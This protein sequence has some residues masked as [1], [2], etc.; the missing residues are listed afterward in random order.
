MTGIRRLPLV[1][2]TA[3]A[4]AFTFAPGCEGED[5]DEGMGSPGDDRGIGK[6]DLSGS[7]VDACGDQ[8]ASGCWCDD[9]CSEFGDCCADIADACPDQVSECEAGGGTCHGG[10]VNCEALGEAFSDL[11]CGGGSGPM[12]PQLSC[13]VPAEDP[14][15]SECEAG[16]G[17][18]H[19]G[20][21]NCE[22]LG[23]AFSDL[24]C[25][26][27]SGPMSPQLSCCVPA[28]DPEPTECEA[29]GGTC[30]GG[31]VN[32]EALGEAFSDLDCGGGGPMSPQLSCCVPA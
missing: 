14:E 32:C 7:C 28:E 27:G 11:D 12:S 22:A 26:G 21:V 1:L 20:E 8:S 25:G 3:L 4:A 16:G 15:P 6:A 17:T 10:E 18:C 30:H 2:A 24:D 13:C 19:G 29:G 31:E 9:L 23:E 5:A